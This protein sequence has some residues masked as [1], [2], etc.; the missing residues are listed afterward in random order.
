MD[1]VQLD[2]LTGLLL[3]IKPAVAAC[4]SP[5]EKHT[6]KDLAFV[7]K[8]AAENAR[9]VA[10]DLRER[11]QLLGQLIDAGNLKIVGSMYDISTGNVN[12]FADHNR[13]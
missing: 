11:S 10:K 2:H 3:K 13:D 5:G 1:G 7:D 9:R 12:F 6:S 8:V 4:S